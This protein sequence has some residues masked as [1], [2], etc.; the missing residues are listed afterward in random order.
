[1]VNVG[2]GAYRRW[3]SETSTSHGR[4]VPFFFESFFPFMLMLLPSSAQLFA[5]SLLIWSLAGHRFGPY[6]AIAAS[7]AARAA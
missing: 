2:F 6:P 3:S 1:M 7:V 4:R 5:H